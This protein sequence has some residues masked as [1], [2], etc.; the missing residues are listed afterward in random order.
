MRCRSTDRKT[1]ARVTLQHRLVAERIP[2]RVDDRLG[3]LEGVTQPDIEPLAG[4]RCNVCAALPRT[5]HRVPMVALAV[6]ERQRKG[7]PGLEADECA[8]ARGAKC[9]SS[10]ARNTE[11]GSASSAFRARSGVAVQDKTVVIPPPATVRAD[12]PE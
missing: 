1:A 11:S 10:C 7:A 3:K 8:H 5:T 6:F 12:L 9:R 4:D 2:R